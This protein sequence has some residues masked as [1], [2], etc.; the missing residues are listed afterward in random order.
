[1]LRRGTTLILS[2]LVLWMILAIASGVA[3][4]LIGGL[5][6]SGEVDASVVA[7]YAADAGVECFLYEN[8]RVKVT[9]CGDATTAICSAT[10]F[11]AGFG[12][13]YQ[14]FS[15]TKSGANCTLKATGT[16]RDANRGLEVT[17]RE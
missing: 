1:M 2:I 8:R 14:K 4:L 3:T 17:Y 16:F 9:P 11:S 10:E 12:A 13:S 15:E 6:V 7:I 5:K